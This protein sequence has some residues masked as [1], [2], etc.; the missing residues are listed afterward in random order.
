MMTSQEDVFLLNIF[1]LA[2]YESSFGTLLE[3]SSDITKDQ[4]FVNF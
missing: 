2:D 4:P 1:T 3:Q